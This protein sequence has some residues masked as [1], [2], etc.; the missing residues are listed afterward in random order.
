M[1]ARYRSRNRECCWWN[2][3]SQLRNRIL[4]QGLTCG[5]HESVQY[6]GRSDQDALQARGAGDARMLRCFESEGDSR[7]CSEDFLT[8]RSEF[9]RRVDQDPCGGPLGKIATE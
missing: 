8:R 7:L 2:I 1:D 4:G 9:N 6:N 3:P 5:M